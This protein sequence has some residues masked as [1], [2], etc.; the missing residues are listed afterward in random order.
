MGN[1]FFES[2]D[3]EVLKAVRNEL[4]ARNEKL[5]HNNY[6]LRAHDCKYQNSDHSPG[7]PF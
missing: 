5:I 2:G 6:T 3:T 1:A 7:I 4:C